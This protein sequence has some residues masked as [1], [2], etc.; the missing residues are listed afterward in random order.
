[1]LSDTEP[2]QPKASKAS[3][4]PPRRRGSKRAR[5]APVR[6]DSA[7]PPAGKK[8]KKGAAKPE[9][10]VHACAL[11]QFMFGFMLAWF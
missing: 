9:T 10:Q 11:T 7:P 6:L 3:N 8:T 4:P 1:M 5:T 2:E